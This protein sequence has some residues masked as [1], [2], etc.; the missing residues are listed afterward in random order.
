MLRLDAWRRLETFRL[1]PVSQAGFFFG[2]AVFG[3]VAALAAA[4]AVHRGTTA[5]AIAMISIAGS[6]IIHGAL[7]SAGGSQPAAVLF[8]A[9]LIGLVAGLI[10]ATEVPRGPL[11]IAGGLLGSAAVAVGI[12]ELIALVSRAFP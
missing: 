8:Y 5:K 12:H 4:F 2:V 7:G 10:R 6:F 3:V 1:P 11:V 9:G